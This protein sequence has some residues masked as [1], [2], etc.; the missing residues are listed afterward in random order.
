MS[1]ILVLVHLLGYMTFAHMTSSVYQK[2]PFY[3]WCMVFACTTSSAY[4]KWSFY[5]YKHCHCFLRRALN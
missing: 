1:H 2:W 5:I 4:Q 3:T